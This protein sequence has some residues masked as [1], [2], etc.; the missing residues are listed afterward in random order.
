MAIELHLSSLRAPTRNTYFFGGLT[1]A[2]ENGVEDEQTNHTKE[3]Y[4]SWN[5][6]DRQNHIQPRPCQ[7]R[8][9]VLSL[10]VVNEVNGDAH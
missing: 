2:S 8:F 3:Q 1:S 6:N 7:C 10:L 5:S 4:S 9:A